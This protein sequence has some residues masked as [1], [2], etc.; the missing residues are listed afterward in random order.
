[1]SEYNSGWHNFVV[2]RISPGLLAVRGRLL[3][4]ELK[5]RGIRIPPSNR[6]ERA[7]RIIDAINNIEAIRSADTDRL[8]RA[9]EA[10]RTLWEAFVIAYAAFERDRPQSPFS[11]D[12]LAYLLRGG[13]TPQEESNPTARNFQFELFIAASLILGRADV[14]RGEPD[15]RL[16]YHGR[17]VGVA[18]KRVR[19]LNTN[20][21]RDELRDAARQIRSSVG[22]GFIAVNLDSWLSDLKT[23]G[24]VEELGA[25]FNAHIAAAHDLLDDMAE[26]RSLLGGLFYGTW[27]GW[28]FDGELPRIEFHVPHQIRCFTETAQAVEQTREFFEPLRERYESSLRKIMRLVPPPAP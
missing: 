13:D 12:R 25:S 1:M 21:L 22:E 5:K 24:E 16:L 11:A 27:F 10:F 9:K 3:L 2:G 6:I 14:R 8:H 19:S 26:R 20:T 7:I 17:Y 4:A 15:L 18:I 23:D 28:H